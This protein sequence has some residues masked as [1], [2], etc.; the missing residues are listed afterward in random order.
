MMIDL[1]GIR[2]G[3]IYFVDNVYVEIKIVHLAIQ[4]L[5]EKQQH[6]RPML[7]IA[8]SLSY[9]ELEDIKDFENPKEM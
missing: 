5:K 9:V 6:N 4:Q 3:V 8:S 1:V 7:E 2:D